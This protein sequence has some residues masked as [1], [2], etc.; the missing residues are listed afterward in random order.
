M[1]NLQLDLL[2]DL[3]F[4]VINRCQ[5]IGERSKILCHSEFASENPRKLA[6]LIN[7]ICSELTDHLVA[8]RNNYSK[9]PPNVIKIIRFIDDFVQELGT[10]LRYIDGAITTKLPWSLPQPLEQLTEKFLPKTTLMLLPQW[11]YN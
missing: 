2:D 6:K 8:L 11:N 7:K 5:T 9:D 10:H 1:E 4:G 3:I